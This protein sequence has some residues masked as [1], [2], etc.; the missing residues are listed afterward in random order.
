[1][2]YTKVFINPL[3]FIWYQSYFSNETDHFPLFTSLSLFSIN[4]S[5]NLSNHNIINEQH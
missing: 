1:M 3:T 2:K 5:S 4:L